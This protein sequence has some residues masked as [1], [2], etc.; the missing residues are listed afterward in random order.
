MSECNHFS[1]PC[2]RFQRRS[3][4]SPWGGCHSEPFAVIL[5]AAKDLAL[6]AQGKL[7]EE[8]RSALRWIGAE[9]GQGGEVEERIRARFLAALGMTMGAT[10]RR[11]GLG[12]AC[13][14]E[15]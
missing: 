8:S 14:S 11:T 3:K 4:T 12:M 10:V 15:R 5:S 2:A 1:A 9:G 13:H 6:P 7:R